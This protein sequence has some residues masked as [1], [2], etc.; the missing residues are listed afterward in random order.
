MIPSIRQSTEYI[1]KRLAGIISELC[2]SPHP[3]T[4]SSLDKRSVENGNIIP[5]PSVLAYPSTLYPL[6]PLPPYH[7]FSLVYIPLIKMSALLWQI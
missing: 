4:N 2:H 5:P 3:A 1:L 6:I 7:K